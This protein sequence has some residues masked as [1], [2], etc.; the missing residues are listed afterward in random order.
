MKGSEQTLFAVCPPGIEGVLFQEVEGLKDVKNP[1]I[2]EGGV[3]FSGPLK[4]IRDANLHLESP[5]RIL[6]RIA[7]FPVL[8]KQEFRERLK[9]IPW[10]LYID[11]EAGFSV[12]VQ[13]KKSKL[14]HT[15]MLE[16]LAAI[17][18]KDR[19][20]WFVRGEKGQ[21]EVRIRIDGD[22][23]TIS[24]DTS[25]EHLYR[26]GYGEKKGEAPIRE[27]LAAA[28]LIKF[29]PQTEGILLDPVCGSGTFLLE[30]ARRKA[31]IPAG[32]GRSFAFESAPYAFLFS[33]I[34]RKV[35]W[36]QGTGSSFLGFDLDEKMVQAARGNAS[37]LLGEGDGGP[38][39]RFEKGDLFALKNTFGEKGR[40]IANP[41]YGIRLSGGKDFIKKMMEHLAGEF[42][43]WEAV[44]V[45]P[46][47]M[48]PLPGVKGPKDSEILHFPNGKIPTVAVRI[49]AGK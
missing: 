23:A 10:E 24:M 40:I 43:G 28:I 15:G 41:P 25:G 11:A 36:P 45:L 21:Q 9:R 35:Q 12:R 44:L 39:L 13:S 38:D 26:R 29:F 47:D 34:D 22:F 2:L 17:A 1:V 42:P 31:G 20:P 16:D 33:P 48:L 27:N 6:L 32:F 37:S 49:P 3:E 5:V 14:L 30:A 8:S 46:A 7:S 4:L 18:I 19:C